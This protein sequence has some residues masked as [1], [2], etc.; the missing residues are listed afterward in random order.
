ML[1]A[2]T[3]DTS[4]TAAFAEYRAV[5][6]AGRD[7]AK[8]TR[9]EYGRDVA[10]LVRF[11]KDRCGLTSPSQV[12]KHHLDLYLVE[13]DRRVYASETRR[14]RVAVIRSFCSFLL[15][16]RYVPSSPSERLAPL[17][18][19][20]ATPR[21]LSP[22]ECQ[23]L[24]QALRSSDR[25]TVWR[26]A[27]LIEVLLGTGVTLSEAASLMCAAVHLPERVGAEFVDTGRLHILGIGTQARVVA[28]PT[29]AC[30]VAPHSSVVRGRALDTRRVHRASG[31]AR[32]PEL[33]RRRVSMDPPAQFCHNVDGSAR[34]LTGQGNIGGHS[35][36]AGR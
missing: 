5:F 35:R 28:L 1:F 27:A 19:N 29:T 10:D 13:L 17:T 30:A 25:E 2:Q 31:R 6:L 9:A 24:R 22:D 8:R 12:D 11:L 26:D 23:R 3:I 34:G 21:V 33:V 16:R 32:L 14:R 7:L 15:E 4:L 36:K 20:A 18:P